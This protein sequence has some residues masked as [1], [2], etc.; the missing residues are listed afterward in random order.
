[1]A[2][3]RHKDTKPEMIVRRFLHAQ[4]LRYRL[5]DKSLSGTPDIVF[6]SR[7]VAVA[8]KGCFW[9]RHD[10]PSCKLARLPKSRL[11]FWIPKLEANRT[12]DLAQEARLSEAGWKLLVIWE[13]EVSN[14]E[15]LKRLMT[16]IRGCSD[17]GARRGVEQPRR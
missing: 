11:E 9:H 4:G 17:R 2:R 16:G 5:H 12:R 3:I 10:D 15:A 6:P 13:C 7:R 14:H 8:V 1:M